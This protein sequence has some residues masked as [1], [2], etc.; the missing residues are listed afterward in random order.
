MSS[1]STYLAVEAALGRAL[2]RFILAIDDRPSDELSQAQRAAITRLVAAE[3]ELR[4]ADPRIAVA[5]VR[6]QDGELGFGWALRQTSGARVPEPIGEIVAER[7]L[8]ELAR[9]CYPVLLARDDATVPLGAWASLPAASPSIGLAQ[10]A[11]SHTLMPE[12]SRAL[13]AV[14]DSAQGVLLASAMGVVAVDDALE[15]AHLLEAARQRLRHDGRA[16]AES[17][18]QHA[19]ECLRELTRAS[20]GIASP[21]RALVGFSGVPTVDQQLELPQGVLRHVTGGEESYAPVGIR[22]DAVLET[23]VESAVLARGE[24]TSGPQIA[25]HERLAQVGQQLCLAGAL[26]HEPRPPVS[27]P[28]IAWATELAAGGYGDAWRPSHPPMHHGMA[29]PDQAGS[30]AT[31]A[32]WAERVADANLR[33]VGIAVERILRALWEHE[34]TESLIDAVIAWENLVGTS[35]ETSFRLT[36]A[37]TVLCEPDPA[38][39]LEHRQRL[40]R[41]Y[42]IRSSLV[43]GA[44][45]RGNLTETRQLAI[46]TGLDALTHLIKH[47]PELLAIARSSDRADVL[48]LGPQSSGATS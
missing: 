39:R 10:V 43:H 27:A 22:A 1:D 6:M 23:C 7:L 47:R 26:A 42:G 9:D 20:N 30:Y 32:E 31:F 8:S 3:A 25:G 48:L 17:F 18:M 33:H 28:A 2:A 14:A 37:L 12:L 44:A 24:D 41:V 29:T 4:A 38:D 5:L 45:P 35:A 36:A 13:R 16:G 21:V 46:A 15:P 40:S 34:W 19:V 11:S